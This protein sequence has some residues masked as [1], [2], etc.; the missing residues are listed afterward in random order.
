[1]R[2]S[3]V[4]VFVV[5]AVFSGA[6]WAQEDAQPVQDDYQDY[7]GLG[8]KQFKVRGKMG[9][10]VWFDDNILLTPPRRM[11]LEEALA[12][13]EDDELVEVTP[14]SIRLRKRALDPN[15]RKREAKRAEA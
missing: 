4:A 1:M 11:S 9:V 13:I 3:G 5:V 15:Q 2:L 14:K 10:E 12:Y 6:A 8:T 7:L